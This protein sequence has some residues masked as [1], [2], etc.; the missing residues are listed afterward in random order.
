MSEKLNLIQTIATED[1]YSVF[2]RL[3]ATSKANEVF[4]GT[5]PFTVFVPTNDAFGKV[6]DILMNEILNEKDQVRLKG[7]LSYHIL[8]GKLLAS[9]VAS[10]LSAT[11]VTGQEVK[12]TDKNGIKIN[13]AGMLSRNNEATNGVYHAIDTV[14]TP[15]EAAATAGK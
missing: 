2:T 7:I 14:L 11:T 9:N 10:K 6:P 4:D 3:M 15:P 12:I 13:G 8:P 5:G 1:K